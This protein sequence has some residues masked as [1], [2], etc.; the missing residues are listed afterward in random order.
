[1]ALIG[2]SGIERE[3]GEWNVALAQSLAHVL[4]P[5]A[6]AILTHGE[7]EE[8]TKGGGKVDRVDTGLPRQAGQVDRVAE[9]LLEQVACV[10]QPAGRVCRRG[11]F[12]ATRA[13]GQDFPARGFDV[14]R[15]IRVHVRLPDLAK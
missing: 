7:A 13:C 12:G 15:T 6:A 8:A 9:V 14:E 11:S 1:M 5:Q 2:E 4:E 10:T 3:R